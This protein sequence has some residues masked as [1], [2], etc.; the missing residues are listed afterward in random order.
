MRVDAQGHPGSVSDPFNGGTDQYLR[1][2]TGGG[3][4]RTLAQGAGPASGQAY[5]CVKR[6]QMGLTDNTVLRLGSRGLVVI[7]C[8]GG[9]GSHKF[10]CVSGVRPLPR[11]AVQTPFSAVL[12]CAVVSP[13]GWVSMCAVDAQP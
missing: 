3:V 6:R 2:R 4:H 10:K 5:G 11:A 13:F 7:P 9:G 1:R 12:C 8:T